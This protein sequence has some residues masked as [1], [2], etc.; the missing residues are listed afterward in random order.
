M[1]CICE[2]GVP[3][4]LIATVDTKPQCASATPSDCNNCNSS[5]IPGVVTAI[6]QT[7]G[8]SIECCPSPS[9]EKCVLVK[10]D[11][12]KEVCGDPTVCIWS[13]DEA[14]FTYQITVNKELFG[15]I[16]FIWPLELR[17]ISKNATCGLTVG[18]YA[19]FKLVGDE[20]LSSC[21]FMYFTGY[22]YQHPILLGDESFIYS[23]YGQFTSE[24]I[25][26]LTAGLLSDGVTIGDLTLVL[27]TSLPNLDLF[28][29]T[30]CPHG[31]IEKQ[32]EIFISESNCSG[33]RGSLCLSDPDAMD[34]SGKEFGCKK[35]EGNFPKTITA[36][37]TGTCD[38][39][40]NTAYIFPTS[41]DGQCDCSLLTSAIAQASVESDVTCG[42]IGLECSLVYSP[43]CSGS[44]CV[45]KKI[46]NI[47]KTVHDDGKTYTNITYHVGV[48]PVCDADGCGDC[49]ATL[50]PTLSV[51]KCCPSY[52][53]KL[54]ISYYKQTDATCENIVFDESSLV[55]E[56]NV[57]LY[58]EEKVVPLG[59]ALDCG[60]FTNGFE[61]VSEG[62]SFPIAAYQTNGSVLGEGYGVCSFSGRGLGIFT[63]PVSV[64]SSA[65]VGQY[66]ELGLSNLLL[67][68]F[69][70]APS[71]RVTVGNSDETLIKLYGY[72]DSGQDIT[73]LIPIYSENLSSPTGTLDII[74]PNYGSYKY[75]A[76][77]G[78]AN[79]IVAN[80]ILLP[81]FDCAVPFSLISIQI[82]MQPGESGAIAVIIKSDGVIYD[83]LDKTASPPDPTKEPI[84]IAR[85]CQVYSVPMSN[86]LLKDHLT[87]VGENANIDNIEH[88]ALTSTLIPSIFATSEELYTWL[89]NLNS[90]PISAISFTYTIPLI[91]NSTNI[92]IPGVISNTVTTT[93]IKN[94]DGIMEIT[95]INSSKAT[96]TIKKTLSEAIKTYKSQNLRFHTKHNRLRAGKVFIRQ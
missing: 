37:K 2:T 18:F 83:V 5:Y 88:G 38:K 7:C 60:N 68:P 32:I 53:K 73:T 87:F 14:R 17:N 4:C 58:H 30:F 69:Q 47:S 41:E 71:I 23:L 45:C 40:T 75:L 49:S 10:D 1:A 66:L 72:D 74:L 63:P 21:R 19:Y 52:D 22:Q 89:T 31:K 48:N 57:Q 33:D 62:Y 27:T 95:G 39:V 70:V 24:Q 78:T 90:D 34:E 28:G 6:G 77:E 29:T 61:I 82:N 43:D 85:C 64:F 80:A 8:N 91:W 94:I 96:T 9:V 59:V 93:T 54:Y 86:I 46:T 3:T 51:D 36:T 12:G 55:Y 79:G 67:S 84:E 44:A 42:E 76:I 11:A 65:G 50:T 20:T 15:S 92:G 81:K 56:Y 26:V 25:S 16:N 35:L 13:E